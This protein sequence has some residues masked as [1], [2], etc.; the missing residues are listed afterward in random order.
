MDKNTLYVSDLDGTLLRNDISLS[1]YTV[2]TINEL[3]EKGMA[4]TFATARSIESA[5]V[6]TSG[7]KLKLHQS[8]NAS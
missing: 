2:N 3:V 8:Q 1:D 5:K 7:L 4:F 6:F